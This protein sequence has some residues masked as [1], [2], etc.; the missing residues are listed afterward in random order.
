MI[1]SLQS[2]RFIFAVMIFLHHFT[3]DGEG[4]FYAGGPAGVSFF[5]IL[6]G[7][8]MSVGYGEKVQKS[9]FIY[10]TFLYKRLIRVY[11]L[12]LLCLFGVIFL[13]FSSLSLLECVKLLPNLM[14]L[15]SWIPLS[16]YYFSGNGV[17]WCL[18]C[19]LFF[20][21]IFPF[22]IRGF[23]KCTNTTLWMLGLAIII[24][25]SFILYVLPNGGTHP[26]LYISPLFRVI[27]FILGILLYK[28]YCK[29]ELVGIGQKLRNLPFSAKS[30]CELC[31][32][33]LL[34][35][36]LFVCA[37]IPKRYTYASYW[38]L[39]MPWFIMLF[40]LFDYSGG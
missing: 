36:M 38:W 32:V 2:L 16:S 33:L 1:V 26:L 18:S 5:M 40:S 39:I 14:L 12:H 31:I 37:D 8:V 15:Q 9:S 34:V 28:L 4:L 11:P 35:A 22:L 19:M 25:Y 3:I 20:Y 23:Q 6:S 17:S 27:D 24:I 21:I 10:K 13:S 30:V 7:F 29:L